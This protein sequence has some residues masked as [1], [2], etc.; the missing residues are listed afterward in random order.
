MPCGAV[1]AETRGLPPLHIAAPDGGDAC[2][3]G[4]EGDDDAPGPQARR[5]PGTISANKPLLAFNP[6]EVN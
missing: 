2:A 4:V 3:K 6:G 5:I 1:G